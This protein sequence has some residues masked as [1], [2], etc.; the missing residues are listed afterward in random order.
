MS[1]LYLDR[2]SAA[3]VPLVFGLFYVVVVG[4]PILLLRHF[5][6]LRAIY[7]GLVFV[8]QWLIGG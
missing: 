2:L 3:I 7:N 8:G 1:G 5:G 6:V 4:V